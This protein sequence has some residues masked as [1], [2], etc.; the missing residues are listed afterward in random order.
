MKIS[1][2]GVRRTARVGL[3]VAVAVSVSACNPGLLPDDPKPWSIATT[4]PSPAPVSVG[5]SAPPF[6]D[7]KMAALD[8]EWNSL[9]PAGRAEVCARPS[10]ELFL[11]GVAKR[12]PTIDL[13]ADRDWMW[14][15]VILKC[16]A[17]SSDPSGLPYVNTP[18]PDLPGDGP[19]S[20]NVPGRSPHLPNLPG[21]AHRR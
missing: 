16:A 7:P 13:V 10:P 2:V 6:V 12:E 1:M 18:N 9:T 19:D 14:A 4:S 5:E 15:Q 20:P 3:M 21:H 11:A 17:V 8:A